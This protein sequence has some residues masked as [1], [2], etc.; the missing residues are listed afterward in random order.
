MAQNP[1]ILAIRVLIFDVQ[2]VLDQYK[3]QEKRSLLEQTLFLA[4]EKRSLSEQTSFFEQEKRSLLE[5]TSF[6]EQEKRSLL[7]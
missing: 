2:H 3:N 1:L 7:E 4:Q 5:Q 6:F